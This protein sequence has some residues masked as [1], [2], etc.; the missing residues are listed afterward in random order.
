MCGESRVLYAYSLRLANLGIW[1]LGVK[2][3]ELGNPNTKLAELLAGS[4]A[5]TLNSKIAAVGGSR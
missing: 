2:F 1:S 4:S 5:S 3:G